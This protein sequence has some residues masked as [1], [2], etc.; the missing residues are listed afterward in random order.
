MHEQ[1]AANKHI[2]SWILACVHFECVCMGNKCAETLVLVYLRMCWRRCS[3]WNES[4]YMG[5]TDIQCECI[6]QDILKQWPQSL[7][8]DN[9]ELCLIQF[10]DITEWGR[11]QPASY[12]N[13]ERTI[14]GE[15][16]Y[17]WCKVT[18][19]A[20]RCDWN[21]RFNLW[22]LNFLC[23]LPPHIH[24][25]IHSNAHKHT[26][27]DPYVR[28]DLNTVDGDINLDSVL[29][30]TKKKVCKHTYTQCTS[31]FNCDSQRQTQAES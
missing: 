7:W 14:F 16:R 26:C 25:I 15:K 4:S 28:I 18:T 3:A 23:T 19:N 9:Y 17:I 20:I 11:H 22:L 29:T 31:N 13:I 27:S 12:Q 8:T 21:Y 30:K 5:S 24:Q 6:L 2:H 10:F 1:W